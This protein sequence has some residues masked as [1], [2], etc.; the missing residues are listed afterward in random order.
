MTN[1]LISYIIL[2][3]DT[4]TPLTQEANEPVGHFGAR[5]LREMISH[6]TTTGCHIFGFYST[7]ALRIAHYA[8]HRA[9]ATNV[10]IGPKDQQ[11]ASPAL[12][13]DTIEDIRRQLHL[14]LRA[15][16]VDRTERLAKLDATPHAKGGNMPGPRVRNS[17][18]TPK[19]VMPSGSVALEE[20][21]PVPALSLDD[22]PF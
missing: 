19:P 12:V 10:K 16:A 17:D 1:N 18:I 22:A 14:T 13:F 21:K 5:L 4:H 11:E 7:D 6:N 20:P 3:M 15:R 2:D 8:A 9:L